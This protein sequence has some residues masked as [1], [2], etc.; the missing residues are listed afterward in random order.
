MATECSSGWSNVITWFIVAIG[1]YAVHR[2]TLSRERRK[3]QREATQKAIEEIKQIEKS[4]LDFHMANGHSQQEA[5]T[6]TSRIDRI[7]RLIQRPPL[8]ALE[9]PVMPMV[10]FRK[11]IT[12]TNF[13]SSGFSTQHA[14]SELLYAIR[15]A[16]D[17][18]T[19]AIE[20]QRDL[21]IP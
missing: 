11:S 9:A 21:K 5:D 7:L 2:A 10:K 18:F 15:C 13:D 19:T 17:D 6:L 12:L 16:T 20:T 8:K 14:E 4:A 3:E 1:W